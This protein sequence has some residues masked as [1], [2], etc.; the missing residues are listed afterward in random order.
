M[1]RIWFLK[2]D[3]VQLDWVV[4]TQNYTT[5]SIWGRTQ[6]CHVVMDLNMGTAIQLY[7]FWTNCLCRK[8]FEQSSNNLYQVK[9]SID[10]CI[11][12]AKLVDRS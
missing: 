8:L 7:G 5:V 3:I 9:A 1:S 6:Y 11:P 4:G 2:M 12:P 10:K